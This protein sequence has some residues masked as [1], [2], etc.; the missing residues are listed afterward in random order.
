MVVA[1]TGCAPDL[2]PSVGSTAQPIADG[3]TDADD[4]AVMSLFHGASGSLCTGTLIAPNVLL[5]ARH[6]VSNLVD[7]SGGK[8]ACDE[9]RFQ[10]P[11]A[12]AGFFVSSATEISSGTVAEFFVAEV[13]TLPVDD[14]LLCG[15]DVAI[16]VLKD[17][18]SIAPLE[19][20]FHALSVGE[21]Y[22]AIGY[23]AVDGGGEGAGTRRRRDDLDVVCVSAGCGTMDIK[24]SEWLGE[25]SVCQGDS[26][27]PAID[28]D[29]AVVGVTSRGGSGCDTPVYG[30]TVHWKT[31]LQDTVVYA[32]GVGLYDAPAW[33]EGSTV[34]PELSMPIG[35]LCASDGDCPTGRC[36]ADGDAAYCS[37][38]CSETALCPTDYT[39]DAEL[40]GVEVCRSTPTEVPI[41]A[42]ADRDGCAVASARARPPR[43]PWLLV[44]IG[45]IAARRRNG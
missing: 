3:Y 38:R 19:P 22:S 6:C 45:L 35:N 26:G 27:G 9:T 40:D 34:D 16:V 24:T 14:E 4:V 31:W 10:P 43:A 15:Q 12:P 21:A 20:R 41:F 39:C 36:L 1:C 29:G 13:V 37:R 8:V 18:V 25:S 23:G 11:F 44:F 7:D 42:P 33:T 30:Y 2:H 17:N 5:T 32:S 28:A